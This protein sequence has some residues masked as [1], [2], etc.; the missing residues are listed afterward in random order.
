MTQKHLDSYGSSRDDLDKHYDAFC[1]IKSNN[2]GLITHLQSIYQNHLIGR[3]VTATTL[4]FTQTPKVAFTFV[5]IG[6]GLA[7]MSTAIGAALPGGGAVLV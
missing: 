5:Q 1:L 4:C 7:S 3:S 6:W 2:W